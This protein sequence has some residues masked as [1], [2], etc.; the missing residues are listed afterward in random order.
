MK[1][2]LWTALILILSSCKHKEEIIRPTVVN[3]SESA[4][5]SGIVKS[6]NQYEVF[7]TVNG[8]IEHTNV[9]E[10]NIVRK[11]DALFTLTN[12]TQKLNKENARLTAIYSS[13]PYNMDKLY[14]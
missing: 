1:K 5:A 8:I 13:V 14:E 10:G 4:Y 7:S 11:G 6:L 2:Y 3:I 9:T 12:E